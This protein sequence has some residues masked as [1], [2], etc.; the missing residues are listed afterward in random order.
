MLE[1]DSIGD[2]MYDLIVTGGQ[3]IDPS[4]QL[5]DFIDLAVTNG[6][7]VAMEKDLKGGIAGNTIKADGKIIVP[8]LIDLHTHVYQGVSHYGVNADTHCLKTGVTTVLDVGSSG[9]D[10]FNGLKQYVIDQSRTRVLALLNLSAIGMISERAGELVNLSY[11]DVD[12]A[13]KTILENKDVIVGLKVRMEK[14]FLAGNA[15]QVLSLAREAAEAANCPIMFHVGDTLPSMAQV[16]NAARPGDIITHIFHS[17]REGILDKNGIVIPEAH[18]AVSR[19]VILDVGHGRGSFSYDVA[20]RA[21]DQGLAPHT[22][23]SDI[24]AHN[25]NGPVYDLPTTL[26]KFL[27][28]GMSLED[29]IQKSTY[30]PAKVLNLETEIGV[31]KV[32][33]CA[34]ITILELK[35]EPIELTD[36]GW[37]KPKVTVTAD[38]YLSTFEVIR[39][40]QLVHS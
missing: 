32:G 23:S 22:I 3:V 29:V 12:Y 24:H 20:R 39:N 9:A 33:A 27:Y 13:V 36:A 2:P 15:Q 30:N 10:T 26:S 21:L 1:T 17:R 4:Q 25:V 8:G 38:R 34:D 31:L 11:A 14:D 28:L 16:L 18:E 35:S 40:G 6:K 19:D 37:D 5:N 7:I